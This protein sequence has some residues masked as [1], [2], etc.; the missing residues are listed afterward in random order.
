MNERLQAANQARSASTSPIDHSRDVSPFRQDS[1][2]AASS[3]QFA[4]T[5]GRIG[6][7]AEIRSR[8]KAEA[9]ARAYRQH[10]P[11]PDATEQKTIS[12][13][14]ALLEYPDVDD[15]SSSLFPPPQSSTQAS[16]RSYAP[17][18]DNRQS[19]PNMNYTMPPSNFNFVQP[20][21]PASA[22]FTGVSE[23]PKFGSNLF[24]PTSNT[25]SLQDSNPDYPAHLV[26]METSASESADPLHPSPR[27]HGREAEEDDEDEDASDADIERPNRTTADTGTYTCTYHGCSLR[28]ESPAKLQKHKR[29]GHRSQHGHSSSISGASSTSPANDPTTSSRHGSV[30]QDNSGIVTPSASGMTP[31][32]LLRNS[33]AGPHRC[34]RINPSTGKPCN[35]IFSR[36]YDLTR[37]EDTIHNA[38]K[39]KVRCQLCTE[40]KT[41]SRSDALTRHMRVVH[42]EVDFPGK[43]RR[44]GAE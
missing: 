44:R 34:D 38:Q 43:H 42:P 17:L 16:Q 12:P 10:H 32:A 9:D 23:T 24:R 36:P 41:F 8:Q 27:D 4:P 37:H 22:S 21:V 13:K 25:S 19:M 5:S 26:S 28:F 11:P 15:A 39:K 7:V 40:E 18:V 29:E 14:D 30:S 33:Q 1:P 3:S 35:T 20:T 6:T 2:F 31:A